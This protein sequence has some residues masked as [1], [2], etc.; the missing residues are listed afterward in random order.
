MNPPWLVGGGETSVLARETSSPGR[1]FTQLPRLVRPPSRID[2]ADYLI[3][4]ISGLWFV[5]VNP[6]IACAYVYTHG[7]HAGRKRALVPLELELWTV[8]SHH[9][10]PGN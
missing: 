3:I 1:D 2:R 8:V 6:S 7:T 9:E 5:C 10:D 4:P